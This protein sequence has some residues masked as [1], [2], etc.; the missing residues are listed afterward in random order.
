MTIHDMQVKLEALADDVRITEERREALNLE[1]LRLVVDH[2]LLLHRDKASADDIRAMI[3]HLEAAGM[4]GEATLKVDGGHRHTRMYATW[5]TEPDGFTDP[6]GGDVDD[7]WPEPE[8]DEGP[9]AADSLAFERQ[10]AIEHASTFRIGEQVVRLNDSKRKKTRGT[11]AGR[12]A[13]D[14]TRLHVRWSGKASQTWHFAHDL[15][16]APDEQPEPEQADEAPT[17]YPE[18]GE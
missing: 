3:A 5:S 2:S 18:E 16:I 4:P 14:P 13:V 1:R 7:A 12:D 15:A 8:M 9:T 11:I 10:R 17:D 6:A